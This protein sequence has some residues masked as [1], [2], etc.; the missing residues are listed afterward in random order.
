MRI[1]ADYDTPSSRAGTHKHRTENINDSTWNVK[2]GGWVAATIG[3][4]DHGRVKK[5]SGP[6]SPEPSQ[7]TSCTRHLALLA[8]VTP[9]H[10]NQWTFWSLS[11]ERLGMGIPFLL[12][13]V[14][15]PFLL[16][17]SSSSSLQLFTFSHHSRCCSAAS[18]WE[19][20]YHSLAPSSLPSL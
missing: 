9:Q 17:P 5:I 15:S 11:G 3:P 10:E 6:R 8:D 13:A 16:F 18:C 1:S 20:I 19:G 4:V 2:Q 7:K 14:S 12:F